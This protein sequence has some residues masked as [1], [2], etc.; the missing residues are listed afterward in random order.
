MSVS[1]LP[2]QGRGI[3]NELLGMVFL[4]ATEIMLFAGFI[5]AYIV[6][7]SVAMVWPPAGQPR[8]P[9]EVTA[10]NSLFLIAS[11][12]VLFSF[13]RRY[14]QG[15]NSSSSNSLRLLLTTMI[16][17]CLFIV[18]QGY[19]WVKLIGYGL[20]SASSIYGAF[21]YTIIGV[22]AVHVFV[23][24]LMLTHVYWYL[25]KHPNSESGLK[26]IPVFSLYWYFVVGVWPVLYY[27]VYLM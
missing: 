2:R 23:G 1:A 9:V 10:F 5:S 19:E 17:G 4:V 25:R 6:N 18:I 16:L 7:R 15:S 14:S 21:F 8:L 13:F 27:L 26:K 12:F 11:A 22:H 20:T 3:S 24:L